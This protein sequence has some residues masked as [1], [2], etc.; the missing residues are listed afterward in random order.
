M[1]HVCACIHTHICVPSYLRESEEYVEH[2][3][4]LSLSAPG[5]QD[6]EGTQEQKCT[7]R[8]YLCK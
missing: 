1:H 4:S 5:V 2:F 3:D 7:R 8:A 6:F